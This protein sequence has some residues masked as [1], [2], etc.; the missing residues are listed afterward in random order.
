MSRI[1]ATRYDKQQHQKSLK[2]L[3]LI[4]QWRQSVHLNNAMPLLK[5]A[6]TM[7][8]LFL[9]SFTKSSHAEQDMKRMI[10]ITFPLEI[11]IEYERK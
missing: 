11:I 10:K 4:T 5:H 3:Q 9:W 8:A 7:G 1:T 2:V 6:S